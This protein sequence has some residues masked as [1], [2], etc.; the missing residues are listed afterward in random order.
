MPQTDAE[1]VA[2]AK[3]RAKNPGYSREW[4]RRNPEKRKAITEKHR[5]KNRRRTRPDDTALKFCGDCGSLKPMS[6]FTPSDF[7][8][9]GRHPICRVCNNARRYGITAAQ[10][11]ALW[12]QHNGKCAVCATL[13]VRNKRN[14][15]AIDHKHGTKIVRG[16]LCNN[17]NL[18][19]GHFG[20]DPDLCVKASL[21][22]LEMPKCS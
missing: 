21:Y 2:R 9:D 19:I 4:D 16:L 3:W 11:E 12:T 14:G 18:A 8:H 13:L 20:D 6:D 1:R 17:C 5:E 7:R 15:F 10:F 22:L